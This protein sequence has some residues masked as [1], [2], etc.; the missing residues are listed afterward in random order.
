MTRRLD[1]LLGVPEAARRLGIRTG[2]LLELV[3]SDEI[4][5]VVIEGVTHVSESAIAE[6]RRRTG[7]SG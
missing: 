5:H 2:E 1:G 4:R 3:R 7:A 6:Y